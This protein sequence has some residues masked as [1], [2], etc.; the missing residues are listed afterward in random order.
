MRYHLQRNNFIERT[1]IALVIVLTTFFTADTVLWGTNINSIYPKIPQVCIGAMALFLAF[2]VFVRGRRIPV[3]HISVVVLA[4]ICVIMTMIVTNDL[5]NGY[6]FRCA[7]LVFTFLVVELVDI[8]TYARY[9]NQTIYILALISLVCFALEVLNPRIFAFAP[10]VYNS[11]E[12]GFQNL[13]FY[14]QSDE[15]YSPRNYGIYREP[16]VYQIYLILALLFELYFFEKMNWKR[17]FVFSLAVL[18][19]LS[20][21]GILAY[22]LWVILVLVKPKS[23]AKRLKLLIIFGA[24]LLIILA[25]IAASGM[26]ANFLDDVFGKFRTKNASYMARLASV[27]VN[28]RLWMCHPIFGIGI[29]DMESK[30]IEESHILYG[31]RINSNTNTLLDSFATHGFIYGLLWLVALIKGSLNF[32]RNKSE[33]FLIGII[34]LAQCVGENLRFSPLGNLLMMYGL[35]SESVCKNDC[36]EVDLYE[37]YFVD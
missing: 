25:L 2:Y 32:G 13:F 17:V 23:I 20:T 15:G 18:T 31:M 22:G 8:R 10:R 11:A 33:K 29:T 14:V 7:T 36:N 34:L 30:F 1:I 3:S 24:A 28:I 4:I 35:L 6:F 9:F 37:A 19:T 26:I 12:L 16:G 27:T 21:T 5:R